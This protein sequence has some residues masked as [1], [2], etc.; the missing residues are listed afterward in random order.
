M[1]TYW[2]YG[3]RGRGGRRGPVWLAL[4][5]ICASVVLV[6]TGTL[7]QRVDRASAAT[8]GSGI[9]VQT[10][11]ST[12]GVS[13]SISGNTCTMTFSAVGAMRTW[14]V[15][16]G[17][18]TNVAF[19]IKGGRGGGADG[20]LGASFTGTITSLSAGSV[21]V[22]VGSEGT[23]SGN[24]ALGGSMGGYAGV[25]GSGSGGGATDI[26][27]GGNSSA[28]RKIVAGGGGGGTN[29]SFSPYPGSDANGATAG[30]PGTDSTGCVLGA[31]SAAA[32]GNGA[33]SNCRQGGGGYA[34]GGAGGTGSNN[35]D[36]DG[37]NGGRGSS[38]IA[39][40]FAVATTTSQWSGSGSGTNNVY[41]GM[42]TNNGAGSLV[43]T[44][45]AVNPVN[46][47]PPTIDPAYPSVGGTVTRTQGTWTTPIGT[48]SYTGKW[49]RRDNTTFVE[50]DIP[51][52][53]G[54]TYVVTADDLGYRLKYYE[55][56]DNGTATATV[57][58]SASAVV[59]AMPVFTT[60]SPPNNSPTNQAFSY[61]FAASGGLVSYSLVNSNLP[62]TLT[63]SGGTLSGT[64]TV[65]GSYTYTVRAT[66][67]SGTVDTSH[68]LHIGRTSTLNSNS[69]SQASGVVFTTSPTI[70]LA[71]GSTAATGVA[72]TAFIQ[73]SP[74]GTPS[75]GGTLTQTTNGSGVATFAGLTLAGQ[76]G[77]Y[78]IRFAASGWPNADLTV[79]LGAGP[80]A[81]LAITT[82]PVGGVLPG[83]T[84]GTVPVVR[85]VDASGNTVT[86]SA[87]VVTAT[88][89]S[90]S[91]N[92]SLVAGSATASSGVA[93]FTGMK[94]GNAGGNFTLSF[95][96]PGL[97]A[98]TS[99]QFTINRSSQTITFAY[100]GGSKT[101][102]SADFGVSASTTSQLPVTF[103]SATPLVCGVSGN[104]S[105]VSGTTGAVV[106]IDG[107]GSCTIHA[108][109]AGDD[110]YSAATR[111]SITFSVAQAAQEALIISSSGTVTFGDA[112]TLT[113][114]GGSGT[115]ALSFALVGGAGTAQCTVN[116]T[117]G[118][119]TFGAAGT[120][121]VKATKDADTNYTAQN[122]TNHQITV[123]RAPQTIAITSSVPA[124][125]LPG[126][127]YSV[128][129][130]TSSGLAPFLSVLAGLG[131]VCSI[132]GSSSPAT[133]T[134]L[135]SGTC[136][137]VASQLGNGNYSAVAV[138]AQQTITVGSLNQTISFAPPSNKEFGDPAGTLV[139]S[140]SSGL[141]VTLTNETPAVCSL[142]GRSVSVLAVGRCTITANQPG[143]SVWS[144]A[145][146]VSRSFDIVGVLPNAATIVSVSAQS[147]AISVGFVAPG[148]TGGFPIIGYR[149]VAT[150][151]GGGV[152]VSSNG[153]SSSPCVIGG[154]ENGTEYEVTVAAINSIGV[155]PASAA[156]PAIT[157]ATA[158]LA[159]RNAAASAGN[160]TLMVDWIAP[161]DLG[162]G[163]FTRFELR[164]RVAGSS[165]PVSSTHDVTS[166]ST[167]THTFTG[168][169]NGTEYEVQIVTITTANQSAIVGNTTVVSTVPRTVPS[170]P[171][172]V[173][174][175]ET[176]PRGATISWSEP[177][178]NGG[179]TITGYTVILSGGASCGVVS[180]D[181]STRVGSCSVTGLALSTTY[182]ISV[183]ATNEVGGGP[184]A[185]AS[186]T[187]RSFST[188]ATPPPAGPPPCSS[189]AT[190]PDDPNRPTV[191]SPTPTTS[192]VGQRPGTV[193]VSDGVA[194]VS[195]TS[196]SGV[197][198][199]VDSAGRLV[200]V[201]PDSLRVSGSG[202]LATTTV[203]MWW[204]NSPSGTGTV[205]STGEVDAT[206]A[207][208]GNVATGEVTVS[209]DA[210]NENGASRRFTFTVFVLATTPP[211]L[212]GSGGWTGGSGG[213]RSGV[214]PSDPCAS[215]VSVYP[216]SVSAPTIVT[217]S[218]A[219]T[220]P[221]STTIT[222]STGV[223]S[224][225]GG[226]GG[227]GGASTATNKDG[228]FV[229]R[230]PGTLP[231]SLGGLRP[232]SQV[233]VWIGGTFS[234]TGTVSSN[235][236]ITLNAPIP[237][238][239]V[240]NRHVVRI[241]AV[242]ANGTPV[243][244]LYGIN[245]L[246]STARL[247]VTGTDVTPLQ[248]TGMWM[249][250]AGILVARLRRRGSLGR[251]ASPGWV[252]ATRNG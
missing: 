166:V 27:V 60:N 143:N 2:R 97:T 4:G 47:A 46:T 237:P 246:E 142:T 90:G 1:E 194:T 30:G 215:C 131:T 129:A 232:G 171:V 71:T 86:T 206:L 252:S 61:T 91:Q 50:T 234:V 128:T 151:T 70:T 158:A 226:P 59:T 178:E 149:L 167:N 239:L 33:P 210:V 191:A 21:Y 145:S 179:A 188:T 204:S 14:T 120:C 136:T 160:G 217:T 95:S 18:L 55:T 93:T 172:G 175:S 173:G 249:L 140:A 25:N 127:T 132:S 7:P 10:V 243:S 133:V 48:L 78:T 247:P 187:T 20:S 111:Q 228:N 233:T 245:L 43:L 38:Y 224:T 79:T 211:S 126:G 83:A 106:S 13:V 62:G 65:A 81:A 114:T 147:A 135:A 103:T 84:L 148:F 117:T 235:G 248:L 113:T 72:V 137:V 222:T 73:S 192:P 56:A 207:M 134:F 85:V 208:P 165:W 181:P 107:V 54:P 22:Y 31:G 202:L 152:A 218:P 99:S 39:P 104:A 94:V 68:T 199:N 51:N 240:P 69:T 119:M 231:V 89:A 157:P 57:G 75:L 28:D 183:S 190:D 101:Y 180:I 34:G 88:I 236:T 182:T 5:M 108:D 37:G 32:G 201:A 220:S 227:S 109:Q 98:V 6:G 63:L 164:L 200:V 15:P 251:V 112:L 35:G 80:A 52:A 209:V 42:Y 92:A 159:V 36:N 213:P 161:D 116:Q 169:V 203:S 124:Q 153:C 139:V 177:L 26:R 29:V 3:T 198:S 118:A 242:D 144:A 66:N 45:D 146:P 185:I 23:S 154:L 212:P 219:G 9:C 11:D 44:F 115:G 67:S 214:D 184:V 221:A 196:T 58:S 156:S 41:A 12:S 162:G 195:L 53:T 105:A 74:G 100:S 64:P 197:T 216:D 138:E 76:S 186:Y 168:L 163:T 155:G 19:T 241:D 250:V 238:S 174:G 49:V 87:A 40:G 102:T 193:T 230:P 16:A 130:S 225:L 77:S 141:S 17:G 229:V 82:Q 244:F 123:A 8:V 121:S 125:P 170:L 96:S 110:Q 176:T 189:C 223:T 150:P 24:W 205:S 122:S